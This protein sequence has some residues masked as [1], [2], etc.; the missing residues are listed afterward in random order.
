MME[1]FEKLKTIVIE[2]EE[3]IDVGGGVSEALIKKAEAFLRV[4]FPESLKLYL[5]EWGNLAIGPLEFYGMTGNDDFES[6]KIPDG[7]WFTA[8]E[9]S[10]LGLPHHFFVLLNNEGDEFHCI[11]L[12]TEEVK[13]WDTAQKEVV[14]TKG[15]N[16]F[17]YII[18]EAGEFF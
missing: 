5:K 17:D 10:A 2:H 11:D 14:V 3:C 4:S 18:E 16:L 13:S 15:P 6:S 1:S 7:V 9:R 8:S 12:D